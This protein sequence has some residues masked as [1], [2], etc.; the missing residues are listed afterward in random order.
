MEPKSD[1]W[2]VINMMINF[3]QM[4]GKDTCDVT[5]ED[6]KDCIDEYSYKLYK[7]KSYVELM[8]LG[9]QLDIQPLE[10]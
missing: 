3:G 7:G 8:Q 6:V 2:Y 1:I 5:L 9:M 4:C 10:R